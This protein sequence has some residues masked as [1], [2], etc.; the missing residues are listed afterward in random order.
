MMCSV[1]LRSFWFLI[2]DYG[3]YGVREVAK[4]WMGEIWH[5][6]QAGTMWPSQLVFRTPINAYLSEPFSSGY[7]PLFEVFVAQR[8]FRFP[9]PLSRNEISK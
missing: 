7:R 9:V 3:L 2:S 5:D 4:E 8:R 6:S 1:F